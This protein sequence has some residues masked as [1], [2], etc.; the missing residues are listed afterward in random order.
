M[1]SNHNLSRRNYTQPRRLVQDVVRS[2]SEDEKA[3][4][5]KSGQAK[6]VSQPPHKT[7][8]EVVAELEPADIDVHDPYILDEVSKSLK[9]PIKDSFPQKK[10]VYDHVQELRLRV[11]WSVCAIIVGGS[12]GYHLREPIIDILVRPLG[13]QLYYTNPAGGFDFLIKI[14]LFFGFLITIPVVIY[15]FIKFVSPAIPSG[16]TYSAARWVSVSALLAVAGVSFAYFVSLPAALYFLS[17]FNSEYVQS[18]ISA[19]EYFSFV[20]LYTAGFAA[21]FQMPLIIYIINKMTPLKPAALMKKQ[22]IVILASFIIAAILTPTPDPINQTL[23]AAPII[24]LYQASIGVVWQSNK[25]AKRSGRSTQL[26][27]A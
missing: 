25:R 23:M 2:N 8:T 10:T 24:G 18:L 12:I 11:M 6:A 15:N 3:K 4:Q 7:N 16:V 5:S 20:M 17:S 27:Y 14:C 22:R 13:Q 26:G 1:R 21:L 9:R 19:Q